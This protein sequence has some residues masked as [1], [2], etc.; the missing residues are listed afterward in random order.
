MSKQ[1]YL[2]KYVD[3]CSSNLQ[4]NKKSLALFKNLGIFENYIIDNF[5]IGYSSGNLIELIGDNKILTDF[6][7]EIGIIKNSKEDFIN[8]LTIPIY[9]ENKAIV[10]IAFYNP[11]PQSKNKLQFLNSAGI[12]NSSF[13]KN[14]SEIILT[15]SPIDSLLLIQSNYPNTTFLIGDDFKYV[16]FY[17]SHNIRKAIFTFDGKERLFFELTKNGISARRITIDF[18]KLKTPEAVDY[19][20]SVFKNSD[21][22]N[23]LSNDMIQEIENGF[24]FQLPHLSYRVIGNFT[25]NSM[26]LKANIKAFLCKNCSLYEKRLSLKQKSLWILSNYIKIVKDKTSFLM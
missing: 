24:L 3:L 16:D 19:L 11:Y 1:E 6:F 18:D 5:N 25:E 17:K 9:D 10:N 12:F 22:E 15:E 26:R 21:T 2:N 20:E 4:E 7:T 8:N 23:P 13:L 14:N